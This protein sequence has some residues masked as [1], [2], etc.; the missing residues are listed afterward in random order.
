M[1]FMKV[2][3]TRGGTHL[4]NLEFITKINC[5]FILGTKDRAISIDRTWIQLDEEQYDNLLR[6]LKDGFFIIPEGK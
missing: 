6:F 4:I 5:D 2:T 3:D 1:K